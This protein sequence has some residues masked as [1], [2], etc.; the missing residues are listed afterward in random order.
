MRHFLLSA[1]TLLLTMTLAFGLE[2]QVKARTPREVRVMTF[3]LRVRTLLD[4]PNL[5]D[6]RR[7]MVVQRVRSFNPDLLGTQEGWLA[8][9]GFL[10]EQLRDYTFF[11]VGRGD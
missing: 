10:R 9:E 8:M 6:R 7:D 3:N 2:A 5:W 1:F 11:G 4:G